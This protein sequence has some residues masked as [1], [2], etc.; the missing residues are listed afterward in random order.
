MSLV[1]KTP[2]ALIFTVVFVDLLGFGILVPILPAFAVTQLGA[3]ESFV[4][5]AIATYSFI[6]FLFNPVF[7][8]LS[9]KYGR[10]HI[11][12]FTLLINATGYIIF[13]F[14]HS[15]WML[16]LSRVVSGIGGSTIGVAQAYIAD[17]TTK[18]ERAK[19]MGLI[20]V[21]FG[22]GFVFG[23][24][25]GGVLAEFGYM[26]TGFAAAG[27]SLTAFV[28]CFFFLPEPPNKVFGGKKDK[29]FDFHAAKRVLSNSTIAIPI[30]LVF[31]IIF[32][33][34]NIYGTLA[35]LGVK[36]LGFSDFQN[37]LQF[38]VIGIVS[39]IV[40][41]GFVGRLSKRLQ[42]R[43]LIVSGGIFMSIGL[44]GIPL[45]GDFWSLAAVVAI[46]SVGSGILQPTLLSLVSKVAP[47]NEQ[48]LVLGMNQSVASFARM[49]GPLWGGFAFQYL[50]YSIPFFTGAAFTAVIVL[51]S[52]FYF[53]KFIIID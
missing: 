34:A 44:A 10:R 30:L 39:A 25:I 28:F 32:S 1:K 46:L 37:G 22:L 45:A 13:A 9:D 51:F 52:I 49:L 7:G 5:V 18:Q 27:A 16:L 50:G 53:T 11:I 23:P 40:Q 17:V 38:G 21:A 35:M 36:I 6:Q 41:G 47:E 19:G 26:V 24:L 2:L 48:G 14:S 31:I 15:W 4:G 3:S 42:D 33:V 20:G 29:V 43:M 12:V 8:S